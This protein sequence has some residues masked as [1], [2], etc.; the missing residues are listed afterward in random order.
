MPLSAEN[1]VGGREK[2][3]D[4]VCNSRIT[5]DIW[6]EMK[7]PVYYVRKKVFKGS[8]AKEWLLAV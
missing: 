2:V 1:E 6:K 4:S 7:A 3:K 8:S 5:A